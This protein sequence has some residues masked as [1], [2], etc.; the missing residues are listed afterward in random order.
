MAPV[1]FLN[2][3]KKNR[4]LANIL[5]YSLICGIMAS[6]NIG[7]EAV[8]DMF[9]ENE[10]AED[11]QEENFQSEFFSANRY[12]GFQLRMGNSHVDNEW[13][14]QKRKRRSDTNSVDADTFRQMGTDDKL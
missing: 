3:V 13:Q 6:A 12:K 7:D 5:D 2:D 10:T 9:I 1:V 11:T 4:K 8:G 14:T